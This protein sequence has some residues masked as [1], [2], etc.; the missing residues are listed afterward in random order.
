MKFPN[1]SSWSF[2]TAFPIQKP[3]FAHEKTRGIGDF[4][5]YQS[6]PSSGS[7]PQPPSTIARS[8]TQ[9]AV[10]SSPSPVSPGGILRQPSL[11][12]QQFTPKGWAP[13]TPPATSPILQQ[14]IHPVSWSSQQQQNQRP[15]VSDRSIG[16]ELGYMGPDHHLQLFCYYITS[17]PCIQEA[18]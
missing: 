4:A 12:H 15:Q 2:D 18:S 5:S 9:S 17:S 7:S 13:V 3:L 11:Y 8:S 6:S 1:I 14:P 10:P 16:V